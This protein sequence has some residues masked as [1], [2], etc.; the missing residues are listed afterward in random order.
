LTLVVFGDRVKKRRSELVAAYDLGGLDDERIIKVAQ[1]E[2]AADQRLRESKEIADQRLHGRDRPSGA[3]DVDP[4]EP[5]DQS[6]EPG[7]DGADDR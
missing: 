4:G 6:A 1:K 3:S 7:P 5:V 2:M